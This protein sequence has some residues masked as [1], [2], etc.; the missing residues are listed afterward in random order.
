MTVTPDP[1]ASPLQQELLRVGGSTG[2][3][4][5]L[6]LV[7]FPQEQRGLHTSGCASLEWQH[8]RAQAG[9]WGL[10]GLAGTPGSEQSI[11]LHHNGTDTPPAST[12]QE[13]LVHTLVTDILKTLNI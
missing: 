6:G 9:I 1:S 10:P 13:S 8:S 5:Q 4:T 3:V 7:P 11:S 2:G 12:E